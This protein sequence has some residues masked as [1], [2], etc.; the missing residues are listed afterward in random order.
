MM[1]NKKVP[2]LQ[3]VTKSDRV[4]VWSLISA[5]FCGDVGVNGFVGD[6]QSAKCIAGLL[7]V[8]AG[9]SGDEAGLLVSRRNSDGGAYV[10]M[11]SFGRFRTVETPTAPDKPG[12]L[13][14][15]HEEGIASKQ[16]DDVSS[17][18]RDKRKTE[19]PARAF[20]LILSVLEMSQRC[21]L[22]L[23]QL[24]K[25]KTCVQF[26]MASLVGPMPPQHAAATTTNTGERER[27][28]QLNLSAFASRSVGGQGPASA[29]AAPPIMLV[30]QRVAPPKLPIHSATTRVS[31]IANPGCAQ[32]SHQ[33]NT[34]KQ[35][36]P[37][38]AGSHMTRSRSMVTR[39][40]RT[41]SLTLSPATI[42]ATQRDASP[43]KYIEFQVL[44][45]APAAFERRRKSV[46]ADTASTAGYVFP[47]PS[48]SLTARKSAASLDKVGVKTEEEVG[49]LYHLTE[50]EARRANEE[51]V[52]F[53]QTKGVQLA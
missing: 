26:E 25:G 5:N 29:N 22:C 2:E 34:L 19:R 36:G 3:T 28:I 20:R 41:S 12:I 43:P 46:G 53:M 14:L 35:P 32:W 31:L 23:T 17:C 33:Y 4:F 10:F 45:I 39:Y 13:L 52:R 21:H 27:R 18:F 16:R 48:P 50:E 30:T 49:Y 47:S 6:G 42:S 9:G 37:A 44:P 7:K 11:M 38:N 8:R 51:Y 40:Q 1:I 24:M 15:S